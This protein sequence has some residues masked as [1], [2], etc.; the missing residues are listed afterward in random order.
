MKEEKA[1]D[2]C[3]H[4]RIQSWRFLNGA[5]AE[6]WSCTECGQRF[7]PIGRPDT[8]LDHLCRIMRQAGMP[9]EHAGTLEEAL[10]TLEWQIKALR[11]RLA[12]SHELLEQA[13]EAL[14]DAPYM[15]N[16]DDHARHS[17]IADALRESL[18]LAK[19]DKLREKLEQQGLNK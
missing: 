4:A 8:N 13:V 19:W 12:R 15:S 14:D 6:L 16:G 17:K 7:K 3:V 10:D 11:D 2:A 18:T 5:S 1:I 9:T